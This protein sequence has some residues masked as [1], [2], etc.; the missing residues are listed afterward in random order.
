LHGQDLTIMRLG[1]RQAPGLVM[2]ERQGKSLGNRG[3]RR[4]RHGMLPK[5]H[6]AI[7]KRNPGTRK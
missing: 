2:L 5:E 4:G 6:A 3:R 7:G 1:F